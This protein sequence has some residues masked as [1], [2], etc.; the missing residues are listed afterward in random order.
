M[1]IITYAYLGDAVYELYIRKKLIDSGIT[2]AGDLQKNAI[3][4]VSA[5]RQASILD[6]LIKNNYLTDD[7]I[8][9]IKRG[10]NY[11]KD[12]HPKNTDIIT[13]KLSTGFEALIGYLYYHQKNDRLDELLEKIEVK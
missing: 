10:R 12:A 2:K 11:K 8:D 13:Y 4:Y 6:K 3:N 9:I 5:K 7:E 1:N